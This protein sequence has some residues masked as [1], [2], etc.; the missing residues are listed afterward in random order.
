MPRM[1]I[2]PIPIMGL[3]SKVRQATADFTSGAASVA[4]C[5]GSA[6]TAPS[7]LASGWNRM[8]MLR[9]RRQNGVADPSASSCQARAAVMRI[10]CR[11]EV[12]GPAVGEIRR[13]SRISPPA[14]S[15]GF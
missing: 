5:R 8:Q 11:D 12:D 3:S 10:G 1:P 9:L 4:S 2:M 7:T 6:V 13:G 15:P 14:R